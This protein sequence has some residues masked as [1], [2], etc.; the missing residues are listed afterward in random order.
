VRPFVAVGWA[1]IFCIILYFVA[2]Y[3]RVGKE[4]AR[5][6]IVYGQRL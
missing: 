4:L 6:R 2:L 3:Q 5:P 1:L